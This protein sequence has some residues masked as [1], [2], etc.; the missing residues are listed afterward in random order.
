[1]REL[2]QGRDIDGRSPIIGRGNRELDDRSIVGG[3]LLLVP[4]FTPAADTLKGN[5]PSF[6]PAAAPELGRRLFDHETIIRF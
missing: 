1:M 2:L 5:R 3:P 4:Q 6:T